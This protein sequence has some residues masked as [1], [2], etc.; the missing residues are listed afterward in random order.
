MSK[1]IQ[2]LTPVLRGWAN[3]FQLAEIKGVFEGLDGWIRR[4]L[5]VH[6]LASMETFVY[7]SPGT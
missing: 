7:P 4:K 6:H 5:R 3:Y 1:V 2:E